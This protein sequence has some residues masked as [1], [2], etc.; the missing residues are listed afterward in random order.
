[1]CFNVFGH[2]VTVRSSLLAVDSAAETITHPTN[3]LSHSLLIIEIMVDTGS[4]AIPNE[5]L[6]S[7]KV[8]FEIVGPVTTM[9]VM[10]AVNADMIVPNLND[11]EVA[12]GSTITDEIMS[13]LGAGHE[14]VHWTR[15]G[16]NRTSAMTLL[17]V[18]LTVLETVAAGTMIVNDAADLIVLTVI[19]AA[20][21]TRLK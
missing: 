11:L 13:P 14:V 6:T 5:N 9:S 8:D 17:A 10:A 15:V 21:L 2:C 3:T 4:V 7:V 1:M 20:G 16:P 19:D 18:D 12:V